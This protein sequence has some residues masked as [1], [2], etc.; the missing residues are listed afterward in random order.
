MTQ[1]LPIADSVRQPRTTDLGV[2]ESELLRA[3]PAPGS[4]EPRGSAPQTIRDLRK[5]VRRGI[6]STARTLVTLLAFAGPSRVRDVITVLTWMLPR[7]KLLNRSDRFVEETRLEG[8]IS[9]CQAKE[10]VGTLSGSERARYIADLEEYQAL[11]PQ[12]IDDERQQSQPRG[13]T[14]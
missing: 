6:N 2:I 5:N 10:Q 14:A 12:W 7:P 13:V 4:D 9:S 3:I 11:L 1:T 8:D